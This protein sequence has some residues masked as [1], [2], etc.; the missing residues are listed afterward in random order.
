M[1]LLV[2]NI[3]VLSF[4]FGMHCTPMLDAMVDNPGT[5]PFIGITPSVEIL[6][7]VLLSV[8]LAISLTVLVMVSKSSESGLARG[9]GGWGFP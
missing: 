8:G 7:G 1:F 5:R 3:V 9:G 2:F 6:A 4:Y